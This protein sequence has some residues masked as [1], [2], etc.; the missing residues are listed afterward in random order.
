ME[1][2]DDAMNSPPRRVAPAASSNGIV[3]EPSTDALPAAPDAGDA[4]VREIS[5][6]ELKFAPKG[7]SSRRA[8]TQRPS[9]KDVLAGGAIVIGRL[10]GHDP[11]GIPLVDH[12]L[13]ASGSPLPSR[14]TVFLGPDR[15]GHDLA[16]GF[17]AGDPAKPIV[18]G[19]IYRPDGSAG[20]PRDRCTDKAAEVSVDGE[21]VLL[22][23]EKEIVLRCGDESLTLTRAGKVLIRGDYILS[24][25]SGVNR[26]K[27][28]SVQIN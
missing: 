11:A 21:R 12:P 10:A 27:G 1:R 15:V 8:R 23:A 20:E 13:N 22:S 16:L 7:R 24:R 2:L 14:T 26:I 18:L 17:E 4:P 28:G 9:T 5:V 19:V 3:Q 6:T 25:S